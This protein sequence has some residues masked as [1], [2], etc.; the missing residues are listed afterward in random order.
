MKPLALLILALFTTLALA[1]QPEAGKTAKKGK[2]KAKTTS[3]ELAKRMPTWFPEF[4]HTPDI[5]YKTVG[6]QKLQLDLLTPKGLQ[7]E[8]APLLVYIHGGGWSG[9]DRYRCS[10]PDIS[11]VFKRC[12]AAGIVCAT[13][14]YR[15]NSPKA[16]AFDSATDCKDALRFLVKNAKQYRIDPERIGTIGG[17]AGGHL[18]L[19]TALGDPKDYPGDPALAGF[20]PK[21]LRCEVAHYPATDFTDEKLAGRFI[22]SSRAVLMFGGPA[23]QKADIIRL[24]SPAQLIKKDS[25]PVYVFHGDKDTVLSVENARHLFAKGKEAGADIQYTEVKGGTH[26]YGTNCSPSIDEIAAKASDFVIARLTK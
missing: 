6:D 9:G 14:E 1:Q 26:G 10:R 20:D 5:V 11:A 2:G 16:T 24:L 3:A 8:A 15:L 13:I 12:A 18:S 19:V 25:T 21:A 4:D 22:G 23:E 7:S 17:S